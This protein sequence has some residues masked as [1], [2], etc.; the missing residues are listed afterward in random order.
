LHC[1]DGLVLR[2]LDV[3]EV[4]RGKGLHNQRLHAPLGREPQERLLP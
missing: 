4:G 1:A 3:L 2:V